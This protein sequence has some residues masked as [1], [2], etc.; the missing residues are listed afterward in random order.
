MRDENGS[1]RMSPLKRATLGKGLPRNRVRTGKIPCS[2]RTEGISTYEGEIL[3]GAL[4][5]PLSQSN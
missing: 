3:P 5:S 4:Q 2:S 1:T